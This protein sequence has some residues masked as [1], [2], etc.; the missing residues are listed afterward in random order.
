MIKLLFLDY[1][2]FEKVEG[3]TREIEKPVIHEV[4][5]LAS[6]KPWEKNYIATYGSVT[7]RS[8]G[9]FQMWYT[10]GRWCEEG[11]RPGYAE[12]ED[13]LNFHRPDLGIVQKEGQHTNIVMDE[14]LIGL[15][16]ILDEDDPDVSKRY[17]M[18]VG[19][20]EHPRI[21]AFRSPDGMHWLPLA[22]NPVMGVNPDGP[23]GLYRH[24]DGRYI[25]YHRPCWGDRRIACS[26]SWDFVHWSKPRVVLEPEPGDE[27]NVQIYGMGAMNYG[28]YDIGTAWIYHTVP[29]DMGWTKSLGG[30]T[31]PEL[32]YGRGGYCWHRAM[33]GTPWIDL[34]DKPDQIGY[35]LVQCCSQPV[36]MKGEIRFYF[37]RSYERHGE[38][39]LAREDR[40]ERK[41]FMA[42]SRPDRFIAASCDEKGE[43]L[44]RPFWHPS[45]HIYVNARCKPDGYIKAELLD[46][47][48][49]VIPGFEMEQ[50]ELFCGDS[51]VAEILW[52]GKTPSEALSG[53]EIR[54]RLEVSR[55]DL[56][57]IAASTPEDVI[58]YDN[59]SE[60]YFLPKDLETY[61][62]PR[63]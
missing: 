20:G 19:A 26:E 54:I 38:D 32:V 3:F 15:S 13:G 2:H 47:G 56:F 50:C 37:T 16:V 51:T 22:E 48:G 57:S 24:P 62:K 7:R 11:L 52:D 28:P 1:R 9:L 59:F 10:G 42:R 6:D 40:I 36:K 25:A 49:N 55:A 33:L 44:T 23:I 27:T 43:I 29:E 31:N 58:H 53:R 61:D 34:E 45:P 5:V 12:S 35:G 4:P 8:D 41:V 39:N 30:R 60:T 63:Q 21:S 14:R 18:L 46:C 17:K